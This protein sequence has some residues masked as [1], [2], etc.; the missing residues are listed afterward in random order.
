ME[1]L[2]MKTP[3]PFL[4]TEKDNEALKVTRSTVEP[5]GTQ[6][7]TTHPTT[8]AVKASLPDTKYHFYLP[9]LL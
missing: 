8:H 5:G 9:G 4:F 3:A 6:T 2:I 1:M 7:L